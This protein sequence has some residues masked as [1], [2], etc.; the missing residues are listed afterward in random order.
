MSDPTDRTCEER[1]AWRDLALAQ[2]S[3][4][5]AY[6]TGGRPK[7]SA[8][9]QAADARARLRAIEDAPHE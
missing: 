9:D 6:R 4:L 8:L 1:D 2:Q 3:I 7:G 5:A